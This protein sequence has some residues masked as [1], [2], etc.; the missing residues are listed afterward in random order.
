VTD[1]FDSLTAPVEPLDPRPDFARELRSR[2]VAKLELTLQLP[3]RKHPMPIHTAIRAH[4]VTPY[5][6]AHDGAAALA[7]YADAFGASEVMRVVGDDGRL[8]HAEFAIGEATFYLSDEYPEYGVTS[9][10]TLGGTSVTLHVDVD[11]V[12]T[13]Y[14]RAVAAGATAHGEPADQS[15]GARH[16]TLVDPFGHRWMLSQQVEHVSTAHYA[17]RS[18][19]SGFTVAA[20]SGSTTGATG[21]IWAS[22]NYADAPAGI[23][24][25]TDVLGF[26]RQLVVPDDADPSIIHHSQ[27]VWPEGGTLQAG[28]AGRPGNPYSQ[29]PTGAES[30]Y[31]VTADPYA[32][33]ER[34]R[35]AGVEV[36]QEP[37]EPDYAPGTMVFSVRDPEGNIFSV[38][39]YAGV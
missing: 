38:G 30:L 7:F 8:G 5:L 3:E 32:V 1:P 24:F 22:L 27:L 4:A 15:H 13:V 28:S 10:R 35:A 11:D 29:R 6:C 36:V 19:G 26:E 2:L 34:C 12:D 18:L 39:S 23:A 31:L 37:T 20:A 33:W 14:A 17:A 9:P 21:G 16:G 25:L